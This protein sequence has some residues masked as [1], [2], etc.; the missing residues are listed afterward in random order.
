ME[1]CHNNHHG[2]KR[3]SEQETRSVYS[4]VPDYHPCLKKSLAG[5]DVETQRRRVVIL[6]EVQVGA[7]GVLHLVANRLASRTAESRDSVG[8]TRRDGSDTIVLLDGGHVTVR[9]RLL[10]RRLELGEVDLA[11]TA[12]GESRGLEVLLLGE[13]EDQAAGLALVRL[14]D[15][16]VVESGL[17]RGDGAVVR[18]ARGCVGRRRVHG[19][20][21]VRSGVLA[22]E[23]GR[24]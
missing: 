10:N 3:I 22:V 21:Q 8:V 6:K 2:N 24:A 17:G 18:G 7:T 23:V 14:R 20:D 5:G 15:V 13:E 11:V 1:L 4:P 12:E 9:S 19:D 16:E